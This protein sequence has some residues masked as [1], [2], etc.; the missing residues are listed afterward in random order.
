MT[1]TTT[2]TAI[3]TI[4]T[5][6]AALV[7]GGAIAGIAISTLTAVAKGVAAGIPEAVAA[8][9]DIK[10]ALDGAAPPTPAQLAAL[11]AA[12]D[13]ADARLQADIKAAKG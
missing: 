10:A 11:K 3:E 12:A 7:P 4:G 5:L 6:L 1:N 13:T 8:Y 9:G 2:A